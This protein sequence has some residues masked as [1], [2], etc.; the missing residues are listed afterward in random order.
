VQGDGGVLKEID[1]LCVLRTLLDVSL[2]A[3]LAHENQTA[4]SSVFV[5]VVVVVARWH[6]RWTD[7]PVKVAKHGKPCLALKGDHLN[8]AGRGLALL[9]A[10]HLGHGSCERVLGL[11]RAD[12]FEAGGGE[13][14]K[15]THIVLE[16][17]VATHRLAAGI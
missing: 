14:K 16:G 12:V 17:V 8:V 13:P 6:R 7:C 11:V 5:A 1:E 10:A 15:R 9:S 3:R 2:A 4:L